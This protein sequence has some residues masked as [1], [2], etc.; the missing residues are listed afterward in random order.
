MVGRGFEL[1]PDEIEIE[2]AT[3]PELMRQVLSTIGTLAEN[4]RAMLR[5]FVTQLAPDVLADV[6]LSQLANTDSG[7]QA[8]DDRRRG[9]RGAGGV[10][11][12]VL[13]AMAAARTRR[14]RR[15]RR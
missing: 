12:F 10:E 1:A 13:D 6:V 14:S 7:E 8:D 2:T 15:I 5:A 11:T 4:D 3:P 9:G